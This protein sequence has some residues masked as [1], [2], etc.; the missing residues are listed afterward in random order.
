MTGGPGSLPSMALVPEG[1]VLVVCTGNICRSPLIERVLQ[2][3]LDE[4]WGT[5]AVR[6]RS[7]G[8][9]G[10]EGCPMDERAAR[11]LV[12]LGGDPEGFVARRLTKD[13]VASS[14]LVLTAT[15]EHRGKVVQLYPRALRYAFS[16]LDFADLA[17]HLPD[18]ELPRVETGP[19]W[20]AEATRILAARR[21][22]RAPL[23]PHLADIVDP[24]RR[25]D[26]VYEQMVAQVREAT[27]HVVRALTGR[28]VTGSATGPT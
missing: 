18:E 13:L 8:T 25:D 27:P 1:Q 5:G 3:A 14:D 16:Y 6:V 10:L 7:A 9:M 2:R 20:V 11:H 17:R 28:T 23:E 15:R 4:R 21:G 26:A 24:Y 12:A 19:E 22:L